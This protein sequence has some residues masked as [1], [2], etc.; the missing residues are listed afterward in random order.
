MLYI[1]NAVRELR[2]RCTIIAEQIEGE[3]Q[4]LTNQLRITL[5]YLEELLTQK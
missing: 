2:K 1:A 4:D 3:I 5:T